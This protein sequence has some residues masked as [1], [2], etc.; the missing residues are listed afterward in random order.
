VGSR[1]NKVPQGIAGFFLLAS[2]M[3]NQN[4]YR[5]VAIYF[6][7]SFSPSFLGGMKIELDPEDLLMTPAYR[8]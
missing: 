4:C 2:V 5:I 1:R 3:K 6:S 7:P 8:A